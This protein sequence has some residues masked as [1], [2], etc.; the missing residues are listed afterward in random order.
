MTDEIDQTTLHDTD[1][2]DPRLAVLQ[3]VFDRVESWQEGAT[4][5]TV[6]TELDDALANSDVTL[7]D[8]LKS[9]IVDHIA[10]G[11]EHRDVRALLT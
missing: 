4:P 6:R 3:A 2:E 7:E 9:R 5:E 8:D 1:R 10:S 11:A